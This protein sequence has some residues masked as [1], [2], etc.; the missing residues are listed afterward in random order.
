MTQ[1]M[2][3][4]VDLFLKLISQVELGAGFVSCAGCQQLVP[5]RYMLAL[6]SGGERK[7]KEVTLPLRV[8]LEAGHCC[9]G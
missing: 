3:E 6:F 5:G 4:K 9:A 8:E 1:G 2:D 7:G